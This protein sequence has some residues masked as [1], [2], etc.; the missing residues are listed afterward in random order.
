[1]SIES[2]R[3]RLSQAKMLEWLQRDLQVT[4][5][6]TLYLS[7]KE[8]GRDHVIYC[9]LIP[10]GQ[11]EEILSSPSWDFMLGTIDY[12]EGGEKLYGATNGIEPLVID[13]NFCEIKGGYREIS[14][15]FRLFHNLYYDKT[16]NKYIKIDEGGYENIVAIVNPNRVQ[17]R[18][19]EIRQFLAVKEMYLSI[20]FDCRA[21]SVYSLEKL[22][23]KKEGSDQR[24]ELMCW[25]H[26]YGES[27]GPKS[28]KAFSLLMG[29]RLVKPL[30]KSKSGLR[31]F[32]ANK[33]EKYVEF[34]TGVDDDGYAILDELVGFCESD[35]TDGSV[36]HDE[37]ICGLRSK[38]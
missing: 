15:E 3:E 2:D 23:L 12:Y 35:Q 1:M 9:A 27:D 20:Q 18:L 33:K 31:E 38:P 5:M 37:A 28:N 11:I 36:N 34:T 26:N 32:A 14:E 4:D 25:T 6:V 24:E 16:T 17:I 21:R 22:G 13:R 19:K 29:K 30:P 7:D 8:G 10:S